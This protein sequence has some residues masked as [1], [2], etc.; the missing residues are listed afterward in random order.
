MANHLTQE[1]RNKVAAFLPKLGGC[2][3]CGAAKHDVGEIVMVNPYWGG[4]S[5]PGNGIPMLQ[6]LCAEC[7]H[8]RHFAAVPLGLL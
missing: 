8:I 3:A 2:P 1:Q 4:A 7:F 5:H 6:L